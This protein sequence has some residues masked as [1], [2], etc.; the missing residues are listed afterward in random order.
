MT[1]ITQIE[2]A[3]EA[4][5][6]AA[7]EPLSVED[8]ARRLPEGADVAWGLEVLRQRCE[9]RGV[10]LVQVAG[11]WRFQTATEWPS[12]SSR[13]TKPAPMR[14]VPRNAMFMRRSRNDEGKRA[15]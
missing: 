10:E 2:R 13:R 3:L 14:P 6:F 12:A 1:E 8:L 5:L 15:W 7:A 11:R 9:G 4:L